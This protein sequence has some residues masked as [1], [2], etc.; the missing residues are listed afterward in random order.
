MCGV[1]DRK[2]A[3][4]R[5]V[6]ERSGVIV[7]LFDI[8]RLVNA[9]KGLLLEYMPD[10][11]L[12]TTNVYCT[13]VLGQDERCKNCSS[14]RAYYSNETIV[15]L[16]Y[17]GGAVLLIFSVPFE[18]D[19]RRVIVELVKDI[20]KS[21]TV[22]LKD[23]HRANEVTGI[24]DN[25]NKIATTDALTKLYN[26]RYIDE[27]LPGLIA[28]CKRM[29]KP[30]T[31]AMLDLDKFKQIND[32]YGHRAGD[33]VL[34]SAA[35]VISSFIR[36]GSDWA[37]RYGGEEFFVCFP[38]VDV[39][40]MTAVIERLRRNVEDMAIPFEG[41]ELRVTIS[42]GLSDAGTGDT[43]ESLIARCDELLYKAKANG[44]NRV[45]YAPGYPRPPLVI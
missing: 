30:L 42:D 25:L 21:M 15:K 32:A 27:K 18:L 38:G 1:G 22:D 9:E 43:Q 5:E 2:F 34:A 40:T 44:R 4:I 3:T 29:G 36:R 20:S 10:G 8:I 24:I 17:V 41:N 37:A 6:L 13:E 14:L 28:T 23:S 45:E 35:S 12:S 11:T 39:E 26:R 33:A 16:E 7:D 31:A 19:S